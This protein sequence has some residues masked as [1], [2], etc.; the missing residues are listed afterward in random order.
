VGRLGG[1]GGGERFGPRYLD[2]GTVGEVGMNR[3]TG[4]LGGLL[5][6]RGGEGGEKGTFHGGRGVWKREIR[7]LENGY[8]GWFFW[9]ARSRPLDTG[10]V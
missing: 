3:V 2:G 6:K 1:G 7:V 5:A 9:R 4:A 10:L 8:E